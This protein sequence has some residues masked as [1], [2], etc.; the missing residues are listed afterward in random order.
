ME[1]YNKRL[2]SFD[3]IFTFIVIPTSVESFISSY[4]LFLAEFLS[5][6]DVEIS[7]EE[8]DMESNALDAVSSTDHYTS[9]EDDDAFDNSIDGDV[10]QVYDGWI[11]EMTNRLLNIMSKIQLANVFSNVEIRLR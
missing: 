9:E 5:C 7:E 10:E 3:K 11:E 2:I 4:I 6:D 8:I 1:I